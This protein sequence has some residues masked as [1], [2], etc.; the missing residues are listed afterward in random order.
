MKFFKLFCTQLLVK[1]RMIHIPVYGRELRWMFRASLYSCLLWS[2]DSAWLLVR[3]KAVKLQISQDLCFTPVCSWETSP[4]MLHGILNVWSAVPLGSSWH[5]TYLVSSCFIRW[6]LEVN[7]SPSLIAS[8]QEDYELKCRLL[9]DTVNIVD[10]EG[11]WVKKKHIY[12][13]SSKSTWYF[14]MPQR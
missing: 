8:S 1:F 4:L 14:N 11:R 5:I 6:L 9:Q 10:M 3:R 13:V 7:A 12:I 2:W